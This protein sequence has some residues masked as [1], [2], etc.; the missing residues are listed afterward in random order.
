MTLAPSCVGTAPTMTKTVTLTVMT[1]TVRTNPAVRA[2]TLLLGGRP[3]FEGLS[4]ALAG[5][6]ELRP[7]ETRYKD[8]VFQEEWLSRGLGFDDAILPAAWRG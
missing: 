2:T 5:P 1:R 3:E 8:G 4:R 7:S 6:T